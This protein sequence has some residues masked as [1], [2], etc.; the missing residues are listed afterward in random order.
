MSTNENNVFGLKARLSQ[1]HVP[2]AARQKSYAQSY[3]C[4]KHVMKSAYKIACIL[5]KNK[6]TTT[7]MIAYKLTNAVGN[8]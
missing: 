2:D 5:S 6:T 1:Q 4:F 8:K 7:I 3:H